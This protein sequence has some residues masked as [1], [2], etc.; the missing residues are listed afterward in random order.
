M[1]GILSVASAVVS[2]GSAVASLASSAPKQQ[3]L[4]V[5]VVRDDA[6]SMIDASDKLAQRRG[7]ASD[8][9]NGD[10]GFSKALPGPKTT[11]GS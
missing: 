4:P 6:S 1:G 11:L 5:P 10:G 7:G 2:A 9:L 3:A 8:I